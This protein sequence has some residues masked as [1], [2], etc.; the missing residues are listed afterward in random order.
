MDLK[1]TYPSKS[2]NLLVIIYS[3]NVLQNLRY[4]YQIY[5]VNNKTYFMTSWGYNQQNPDWKMKDNLMSSTNKG[6]ITD[7][8]DVNKKRLK[9]HLNQM[10][11][12]SYL[13]LEQ[14]KCF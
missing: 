6:K 10:H 11:Y 5:V 13:D 8:R 1:C 14:T 2:I 12:G 4:M 9:R 3:M 7:S